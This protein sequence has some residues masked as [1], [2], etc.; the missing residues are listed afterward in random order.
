MTLP[1]K[2]SERPASVKKSVLL[3]DTLFFAGKHILTGTI[4]AD[5][6]Q[7]GE[8]LGDS[9]EHD[10]QSSSLNMYGIS[11]EAKSTPDEDLPSSIR[12]MDPSKRAGCSAFRFY[13]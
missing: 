11:D 6:G 7:A 2:G 8:L 5:N 3:S 9:E 13:G 4:C 1:R 10:C 12:G